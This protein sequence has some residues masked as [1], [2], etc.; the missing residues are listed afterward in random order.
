MLHHL[1][2]SD[3]IRIRYMVPLVVL[4]LVPQDKSEQVGI[5]QVSRNVVAMVPG[6]PRTDTRL[7]TWNNKKIKQRQEI[8]VEGFQ[9]IDN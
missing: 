2:E 9:L 4:V 1:N 7:K 5:M 3:K 8:I 6:R